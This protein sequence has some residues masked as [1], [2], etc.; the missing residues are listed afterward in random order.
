MHCPLQM[1]AFR[2]LIVDCR[3]QT[4]LVDCGLLISS[5]I[6]VGVSRYIL[7]PSALVCSQSFFLP[8]FSSF[9]P[10]TH[11]P[12]GFPLPFSHHNSGIHP[13]RSHLVSSNPSI[14]NQ[15][16]HRLDMSSF[17]PFVLT[18]LFLP[19]VSLVLLTPLFFLSFYLLSTSTLLLILSIFS[20]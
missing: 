15:G 13:T 6:R 4:W 12:L 3:R 14:F 16:I 17:P 5:P 11:T 1:P 19:L 10:F 2:V 9:T 7:I 18:P 20:S 8:I